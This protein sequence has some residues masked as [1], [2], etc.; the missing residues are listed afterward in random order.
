M[1]LIE[2]SAWGMIDEKQVANDLVAFDPLNWK[3]L[4]YWCT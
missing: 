3:K 4:S 2:S 1:N